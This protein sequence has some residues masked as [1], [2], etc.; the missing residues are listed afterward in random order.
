MFT[1]WIKAPFLVHNTFDSFRSPSLLCIDMYSW[2]NNATLFW[3]TFTYCPGFN[4]IFTMG[5]LN[6]GRALCLIGS[7][8]SRL[9]FLDHAVHKPLVLVLPNIL[10]GAYCGCHW[11]G[12]TVSAFKCQKIRKV[13][14]KRISHSLDVFTQVS[15]LSVEGLLSS[16]SMFLVVMIAI[17]FLLSPPRN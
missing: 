14:K 7:W 4:F 5:L 2:P 6:R 8:I 10:H 12:D 11:F 3:R 16:K 17:P 1:E 9:L 13:V 15:N